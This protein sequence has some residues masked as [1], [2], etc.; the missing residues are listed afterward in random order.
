[1]EEALVENG[2]GLGYELRYGWVFGVG[3]GRWG[4]GV[5]LNE[6]II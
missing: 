4:R 2:E 1:V 3:A 6:S 5:R